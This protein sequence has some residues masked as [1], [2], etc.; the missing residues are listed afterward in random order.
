LERILS[1]SRK[2]NDLESFEA[3]YTEL[4]AL[5]EAGDEQADR[6]LTAYRPWGSY[7]ILEEGLF[8]QDQE[9]HR[10]AREKAQLPAPPPP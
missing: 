1:L 5:K 6:H 9:D 7:T 8:L 3:F 2:W 10:P 4:A